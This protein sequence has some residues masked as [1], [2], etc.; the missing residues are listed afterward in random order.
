MREVKIRYIVRHKSSGN[1]EVKHYYLNQIEQRPLKEL[2]PVFL[3]DYE[4]LSRDMYTGLKDK[5]GNELYFDDYIHVH[6]GSNYDRTVPIKDI[7][8]LSNLIQLID[9]FGA[10]FEI[11]RIQ[12]YWRNPNDPTTS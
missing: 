7:Y 2:S 1:I 8:D 4:T 11:S 12:C 9:E 3:A 10:T 5:N 6:F